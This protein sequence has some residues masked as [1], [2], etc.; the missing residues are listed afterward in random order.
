MSDENWFDK[1]KEY[2]PAVFTALINP[3][4]GGALAI[5]TL[6]KQLGVGDN[7]EEVKAVISR[8][9]DS[10][11]KLK[12]KT[13]DLEFYKISLESETKKHQ[14]DADVLLKIQDTAI[15]EI[16]SDDQYVRRTRPMIARWSFFSGVVYCIGSEFLRVI[17][18]VLNIENITAEGKDTIVE[19]GSAAQNIIETS[20]ADPYI[21][22]AIF[23]PCMAYIGAR[24]VDKIKAWNK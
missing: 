17:S 18:P 1:I 9:D 20:G 10:E 8:M 5:K 11:L 3:V 15:A 13:L 4:A 21:A 16:H 22:G 19:L 12:L 2:A 7:E 6:S 24:S 14:S 23:A